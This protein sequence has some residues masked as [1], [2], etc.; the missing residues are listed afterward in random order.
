MGLA[1]TKTPT[2]SWSSGL[3]LRSPWFRGLQGPA[4][5]GARVPIA[6]QVRNRVRAKQSTI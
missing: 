1:A 4:A 5:L 2:S 6:P 3:R